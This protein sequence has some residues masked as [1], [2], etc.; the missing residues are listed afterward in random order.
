MSNRRRR[1]RRVLGLPFRG[2]QTRAS[3]PRD[4]TFFLSSRLRAALGG[5]LQDP[6]REHPWVFRALTALTDQLASVPLRLFTGP[7]ADPR[8]VESG[9][10]ATLMERPAEHLTRRQ[11]WSLVWHWYHLGGAYCVL[12]D[13]VGPLASP[14]SVPVEILPWPARCVEPREDTEGRLLGWRLRLRTGQYTDLETWQVVDVRRVDPDRPNRGLSLLDPAGRAVRTD[15]KSARWNE[16]LL[17]NDATPGGVVSVAEEITPDQA[18]AIRKLW[19]DRYGGPDKA[20]GPA[21]LGKGAKWEAA[22]LSPK[23]M[24]YLEQ[25][26]WSKDEIAAVFGVPMM[27]LGDT[28]TLHSKESARTVA[29]QAWQGTLIPQLLLVADVLTSR[30]FGRAGL[31]CRHDLSSVEALQ[32]EQA[33]RLA[34]AARARDLG[35]PRNELNRRY[36]LGFDLGTDGLGD[37]PLV[38]FSLQPLAVAEGLDEE[39]PEAP[40]AKAPVDDMED[41]EPEEEPAEDM[42]DEEARAVPTLLVVRRAAEREAVWRSFV[43][44][45]VRPGERRMTPL[46]RGWMRRVRREVLRFIED[47]GV[48]RSVR[49]LSDETVTG[50]LAEQRQRWH[51]LLVSRTAPAEKTAA[52][53]VIDRLNSQ[54]GGLDV[55]SMEHPAVLQVLEEQG[56][57]KVKVVATV[58]DGV[59]RT[60]MEGLSANENLTALQE[61]IRLAF[62]VASSRAL[63]IARTETAAAANAVKSEAMKAEGI[64]K[65]SW[66]SAGDDEVRTAADGGFDHGIDDEIVD[67]GTRFSNGLLRPHDPDGEPGNVINCRCEALPEV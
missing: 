38:P 29:K 55:V 67:I 20:G 40:P 57:R 50:W 9:P 39:E 63:T 5:G 61:R 54:L 41:E 19:V 25:R 15:D 24:G 4:E 44:T 18:N 8:P 56:A 23:D 26:R 49:V 65:H 42:E 48:G 34:N 14:T 53:S 13:R 22:S 7:L 30:L 36:E 2:A 58:Q 59:K 51:E 10:W 43:S 37:V 3:P 66:L 62:N 47:E 31:W 60:L 27:W 1:R 52:K 6:Y 35:V 12:H 45:V 21:V 46:V 17:D 16:G 28:E 64:T 33:D 11:W 32:E